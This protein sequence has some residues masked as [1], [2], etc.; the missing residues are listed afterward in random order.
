M[1]ILSAGHDGN[2]SPT[3]MTHAAAA[4]SALLAALLVYAAVRK[5]THDPEVVESYARTGVPEDRL[6]LLALVL[7]AGA[8]GLL[9]GIAW[10]PIGIAA[11][12]ALTAYF[13][14]AIGFHFRHGDV[15]HAATPAVMLALSIAALVLRNGA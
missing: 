4:V 10:A 6:D 8:A 12:A 3:P 15:E 7:F 13:A 2:R 9:I 11:A 1:Y 14:V 5:R